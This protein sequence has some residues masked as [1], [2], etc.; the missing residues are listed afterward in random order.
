MVSGIRPL[1]STISQLTNW[2]KVSAPYVTTL[3]TIPQGISRK[4]RN[5]TAIRFSWP[6]TVASRTDKSGA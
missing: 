4:I 1:N 2:N 3:L 6:G 5:R